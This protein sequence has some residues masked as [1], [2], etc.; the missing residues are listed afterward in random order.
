MI[1]EEKKASDSDVSIPPGFESLFKRDN[2]CSNSSS[3]SK[4]NSCST[5]FGNHKFKDR[6]GFPFFDEMNRMIEVGDALGYDVKGCKHSLRKMINGI[7]AS[8]VDK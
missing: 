7:G 6:K 5:S 3:R 2:E 4:G 8:L 1:E